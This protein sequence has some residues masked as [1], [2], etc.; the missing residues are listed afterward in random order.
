MNLE[1]S[2]GRARVC[3]FWVVWQGATTRRGGPHKEEQ[4]RQAARNPCNRVRSGPTQWVSGPEGT[5][6]STLAA[7]RGPRSDQLRFLG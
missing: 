6:A 4:H 7:S 2:V 5:D 3:G 1:T